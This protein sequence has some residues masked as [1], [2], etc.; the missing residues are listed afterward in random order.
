MPM[1]K[2]EQTEENTIIPMDMFEQKI[3]NAV[4]GIRGGIDKDLMAEML[5][6]QRVELG[7]PEED[8][9]MAVQNFVLRLR[10]GLK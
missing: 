9:K 8:A 5:E 3:N 1:E 2:P 6:N 7:I 4:M 10:K